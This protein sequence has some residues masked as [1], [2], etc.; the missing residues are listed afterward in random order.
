[1]WRKLKLPVLAFGTLIVIISHITSA[2]EGCS[3]SECDGMLQQCYSNDGNSE[4]EFANC[5]IS[6]MRTQSCS[7][8][9]KRETEMLDNEDITDYMDLY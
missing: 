9:R 6:A 5:K 2:V 4:A 8:C 7:G 1:M 3:R